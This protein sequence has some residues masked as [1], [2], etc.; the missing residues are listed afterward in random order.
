MTRLGTCP[1]RNS[2]AMATIPSNMSPAVARGSMGTADPPWN[3]EHIDQLPAEVR[4]A[5]SHLCGPSLGA[6]HYFPTY[7]EN[8]RLLR[9]WT[10]WVSGDRPPIRK[11]RRLLF[12]RPLNVWRKHC[13]TDFFGETR[14]PR[15]RVFS[16]CSGCW[17]PAKLLWSRRCIKHA[18]K[19]PRTKVAGALVNT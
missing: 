18:T 14:P 9:K 12:A 7:S 4:N 6:A 5:V 10:N 1:V 3:P 17:N 13:F 11:S 19:V 16:C 15:A 8:S 2:S